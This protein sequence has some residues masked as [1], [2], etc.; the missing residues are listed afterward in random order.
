MTLGVM[1]L[2]L[3]IQTLLTPTDWITATM[4]RSVG[5]WFGA[6]ICFYAL[7]G[8]PDKGFRR[9]WGRWPQLIMACLIVLAVAY[10]LLSTGTWWGQPLGALIFLLIIYVTAH[11]G[12]SF[13]LASILAHPG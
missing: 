8:V 9:T 10:N 7:R 13:V 6:V 1:L 3:G 12:L 4:P 2:I 11:L 5:M